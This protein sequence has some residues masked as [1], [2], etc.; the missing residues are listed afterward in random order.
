[1]L[2][3]AKFED[4]RFDS[5]N[6]SPDVKDKS[7]EKNGSNFSLTTMIGKIELFYRFGHMMPDTNSTKKLR[8]LGYGST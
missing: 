7:K 8:L 4:I 1:M 2:V 6:G 3:V 5:P